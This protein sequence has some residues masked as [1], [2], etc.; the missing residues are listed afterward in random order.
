MK[1]S[2]SIIS[3]LVRQPSMKKYAQMRC[4]EN[5]LV[6][7]PQS[8]T[9]MVRFVYTKNDTLFFVLNHPCAKMEFNYKRNLIKSLL[10]EFN[11]RYPECTCLCVKEVQ[12]FVTNQPVEEEKKPTPS[13]IFYAEQA[14][15]TF[16]TQCDDPT[17]KTLFEAIK[18]TILT[19][20]C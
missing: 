5:W 18:Q 2:K 10:K 17:L 9:S 20:T 19:R 15:G 7:L 13:A 3:H 11:A 14:K 8:F 4:Y 6:L 16:E 1:D 12:A